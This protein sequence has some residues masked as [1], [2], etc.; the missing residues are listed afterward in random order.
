MDARLDADGTLSLG[1]IPGT[2]EGTLGSELFAGLVETAEQLRG[3][4]QVPVIWFPFEAPL[5]PLQDEETV[6]GPGPGT[7]LRLFALETPPVGPRE[8]PVVARTLDED[9]YTAPHVLAMAPRPG[10]VLAPGTT[11]AAVATRG[12]LDADG[13]PAGPSEALWAL[14]HGREPQGPRGAELARDYRRLALALPELGIDVA[15]VVAAVVFTTGDAPLDLHVLSERVRE[16]HSATLGELR[17]EPVD[18]ADH[19][20]YCEL[21]GTLTVPQFQVG[22]PPFDVDGLFEFGPDGVPVVQREETI[23]IAIS[24]PYGPDDAGMPPGG[25]PL[26]MYFHGS[27]GRH[28]QVINRGFQPRGGQPEVGGGPAHV[29]AAHGLAAVGSAHPISPDR[30]PGAS[31]IAYLNFNNLKMF[32]DLFRQGVLEQRLFLDALLSLSIDPSVVADCTR[33]RLPDGEMSFRFRA[34]TVLAMGQSMGGQYTNL[35]GAVE[36]RIG[37]VVPTGAGGYW[38]WFILQTNLVPGV[39]GLLGSLLETDAELSFMHPVFSVLQQAWEP[40][41][42]MVYMQRLG[43]HPLPDHPAR[44]IYEPVAPGDSFFPTVVYDAMALAYGHPQAGSAPGWTSMQQALALADLDGV[45]PLPATDNLQAS[46]GRAYTGLAVMHP[47]DGFSDPH[48][49]FTQL[50]EVRH[51][52]GCFLATFAFTGQA[53]IPAGAAEGTPCPG[54]E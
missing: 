53:T 2:D 22:A 45:R 4:S 38:S 5:A 31:S 9:V 10:F 47:P 48:E 17:V 6:L 25:Y 23:P 15:D 14:L 29:L 13:A 34:D 16:A 41:E 36:P 37:A 3:H 11:W 46:D 12:V 21:V 40:V 20:R 51:Q 52:Y 1:G 18:G 24:L 49:I 42:P 33:L 27:G 7:P 28:D 32:R 43:R 39:R 35:V 30:V 54:L 44:S 8:I 19:A 26:V 50:T